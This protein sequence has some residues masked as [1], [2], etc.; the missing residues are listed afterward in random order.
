[1]VGHQ[2]NRPVNASQDDNL[3]GQCR[4]DYQ[5][6]MLNLLMDSVYSRGR[7]NG[8][9][10]VANQGEVI[11]KKAYGYTKTAP[12]EPYT[13]QSNMQLASVSKPFTAVA[14]LMLIERGLINYDDDI[15]TYLPSLRYK[16]ITVRHLLNHTSGLPD[17][18]NRAWLYKKYLDPE[19]DGHLTNQDMLQIL[20]KGK[21]ALEF[22]PGS[23]HRY[24]NTGYALL[25]L[26]IEKVSGQPFADFMQEYIFHRVGMKNTTVFDPAKPTKML[27]EHDARDGILGDKGIF[28]T[29][30]DMFLWD[31]AL[32]SDQLV[33]PA[34]LDS[35]FAA[36]TTLNDEKFNYG[37]GWRLSNANDGG[38]V[39]YHKG[40]WQ[41]AT[42]MLIRYVDRKRTVI[43]LHHANRVDSWIIASSANHIMD[44][45]EFKCRNY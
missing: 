43:S 27:R 21:I 25:P 22:E 23:R 42:P 17:Y 34:T 30:E 37:Y 31:Q 15:T 13:V 2:V 20:A 38:R 40:Y 7:Y 6:S 41:G 33:R 29:V 32:Y 26:I 35:A 9:V 39:I 1:M 45:S 4:R 28:S 44:Q 24:S 18:L 10:L 5:V 11:F 8:V 36:G 14:T 12:F 19:Q 3:A 16:G